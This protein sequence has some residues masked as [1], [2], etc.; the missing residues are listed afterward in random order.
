MWLTA[1]Q[2]KVFTPDE[3][4]GKAG[5]AHVFIE[6]ETNLGSLLIFLFHFYV[7]EIDA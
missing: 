7:F 1:D 4:W 2:K 6:I 3:Y 5:K